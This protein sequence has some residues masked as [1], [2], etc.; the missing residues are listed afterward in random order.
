MQ[1][2]LDGQEPA[3]RI[4]EDQPGIGFGQKGINL[5]PC[6]RGGGD[7]ICFPMLADIGFKL[8]QGQ[9]AFFGQIQVRNYRHPS[10]ALFSEDLS[11]DGDPQFQE[12]DNVVS[13]RNEAYFV[14]AG[15]EDLVITADPSRNATP[16][17][18]TTFPAENKS[19]KKARIYATAR[20]IYEL[21]L[22]GERVGEDYFNPGLTQYNKTHLYQT[23]DVTDLVQKGAQNALGAW[24][25][26]LRYG[27][28]H[29]LLIL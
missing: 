28:K 3:N 2:F 10:N 29:A 23:Y 4:T 1:I 22:N 11:G 13:V 18:R 21:Y 16:M 19:I 5:N 17:L 25:F 24:C 20:G 15:E 7:F 12:E 9:G 6:G 26:C 27:A 14:T 8:D